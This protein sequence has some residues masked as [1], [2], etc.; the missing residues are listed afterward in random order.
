MDTD[1]LRRQACRHDTT[2]A[3]A[4]GDTAEW[5]GIAPAA[6]ARRCSANLLR[7]LKRGGFQV[8]V[9]LRQQSGLRC[10]DRNTQLLQKSH[11][12]SQLL[13]NVLVTSA[14]MERPVSA[15]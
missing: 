11:C 13:Q 9:S 2:D 7:E 1:K 12:G 14:Y 4:C 3:R 10:I 5:R 15:S 6:R 8:S